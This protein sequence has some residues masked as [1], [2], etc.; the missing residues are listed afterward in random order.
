[1]TFPKPLFEVGDPV[2]GATIQSIT[3]HETCPDCLGKKSWAVMTPA[4]EAFKV[5]CQTCMCGFE[6]L[7]YIGRSQFEPL[8]IETTVGSVHV[9]TSNDPPIR[10]ML[11][12]GSG[13]VWYERDVFA[14]REGAEAAARM[15]VEDRK[16]EEEEREKSWRL[17]QKRNVSAHDRW[18]RH[19]DVLITMVIK[20]L[21]EQALDDAQEKE[22]RKIIE[23]IKE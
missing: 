6:T 7:D 12:V 22:I 17:H 11:G 9:D 5:E 1:M 4:G 3:V 16:K 21:D 2:F 13:Q 15:L 23:K 8:V 14:S 19:R 18:L 10:Y 20:I